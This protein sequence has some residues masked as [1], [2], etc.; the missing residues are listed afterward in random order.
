MSKKIN[1]YDRS[2]KILA[3]YH[4]EIF[5]S[6]LIE[7]NE[8]I[9]IM[10]ENPEINLPEKRGDY[11]WKV[12][13]GQ[14]EAYFIFEFQIKADQDSLKRAFVKCAL[15]HEA[16][17]LPVIGVILYLK[18]GS[19]KDG[20]EVEFHG[21]RNRYLFETIKLWEY[22]EEIESGKRKELAPF[23]ILMS[24]HPDDAVLRKEKELIMLV[25]DE[26]ERADLLSIAMTLAVHVVKESW[27]K[28]YFKEEMKMIKTADIVQEWI[29]EGIQKGVQQGIQQ[30]VQQDAR[31]AVIDILEMRFKV[32][33]KSIIK[34]LN[35]ISDPSVLKILRRKAVIVDS[36]DDFI[37]II[38]LMYESFT[39]YVS[40]DQGEFS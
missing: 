30:G 15:L 6:L 10:V 5:L 8:D 19:Y 2:L 27:V 34:I 22:K 12:R 38:K 9:E 32:V 18:E 23:L 7:S 25:Q 13:D 36:F 11:A 3:R 39:F 1:P 14:E 28:E 35:E 33:P 40:T 29:D 20:Y 31:D 26:K 21:N 4:P 17:E 24:E 16:T 37:Q